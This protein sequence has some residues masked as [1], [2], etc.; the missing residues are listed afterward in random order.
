[1]S[2]QLS[3]GIVAWRNR[4]AMLPAAI[5]KEYRVEGK[6]NFPSARARFT[7]TPTDEWVFMRE[8]KVINVATL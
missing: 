6:T 7:L 1:M 4:T 3:T 5:R 2:N 8:A